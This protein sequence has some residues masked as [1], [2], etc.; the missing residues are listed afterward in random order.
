MFAIFSKFVQVLG[1]IHFISF[2]ASGFHAEPFK[3]ESVEKKRT[4]HTSNVEAAELIYKLHVNNFKVL[5]QVI[6]YIIKKVA[7][8][9]IQLKNAEYY[10]KASYP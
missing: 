5:C 4:T 10:G 1:G 2:V 7:C 6:L 8:I 3:Y 9:G